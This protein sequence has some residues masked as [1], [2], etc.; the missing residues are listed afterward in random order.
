MKAIIQHNYAITSLFQA[1]YREGEFVY[2]AQNDGT[3]FHQYTLGYSEIEDWFLTNQAKPNLYF[4][5]SVLLNKESTPDLRDSFSKQRGFCLDLDFGTEGHKV[6][7]H[8]V[9]PARA[10]G[11]VA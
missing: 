9:G 11:R 3:K 1:L 6:K 5:P 8:F 2:F 4:T 10:Q 7:T